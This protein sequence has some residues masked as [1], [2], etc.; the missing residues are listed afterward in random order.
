MPV[1]IHAQAQPDVAPDSL[2]A[3]ADSI[4]EA[5]SV[6]VEA[7]AILMPDTTPEWYVEPVIPEAK[8]APRFAKA[9][10]CSLDSTLS[11]DVDSVLI[12]VSAFQF[13]DKDNVISKT[14]YSCNPDGSRVG[15]FKEEYGFDATNRQV[16]TAVYE[17]VST[18]NTWK[19]TEKTEFAYDGELM[20]QRIDYAW[21]NE[22]WVADK[23]NTWKYDDQE[24]VIEYYEFSRDKN[25]NQ[26]VYSKGFAKEWDAEDRL[27]LD[28]EY[29]AYS[30]GIWTAGTKKETKYDDNG[31]TIEYFNYAGLTSGNWGAAGSTHELWTFNDDNAKTNYEKYTWS[32]GNWVGSSKE[33]WGYTDGKQ[34]MYAKYKWQSNA[35][36]GV[37]KEVKVYTANNLTLSETYTWGNGD[38]VGVTQEKWTYA[39]GKKTL[40]EKNTW[41]NGAWVGVEKEEWEYASGKDKRHEKFTW[42]NGAWQTTEREDWSYNAKNKETLY[43]KHSLE[44]GTLVVVARRTSEYDASNNQTLLMNEARK[45]GALVGTTKETWVYTSGK[46]TQHNKFTW[47]DSDWTDSEE[48]VWAYEG[49]N[50]TNYEKYA[51]ENGVKTG[52]TKRTTEYTSGKKTQLINYAWANNAWVNS[53]KEVWAYTSGKQTLHEKYTWTNN[54]W[55]YTEKEVWAYDGSNQ[56]LHEKYTAENGALVGVEKEEWEYTSGK[57]TYHATSVWYSGDWAISACE[58]YDVVGNQTLIESYNIT[59]TNRTGKEKKEFE[60]NAA[61]SVIKKTTYSWNKSKKLWGTRNVTGYDDAGNTIE[62]CSYTWNNDAWK[63]SGDRQLTTYNSAKKVIEAIT[64]QWST[65]A[66]DWVNYYRKTTTYSGDKIQC[67]A[68]FNWTNN[69]WL[70]SRR[71]DYHYNA[72]GQNDSIKVYKKSGTELVYS[73]RTVNTFD[74]KGNKILSHTASYKDG[75]WVL[76][77]ME[78]LEILFDDANRQILYATWSCDADSIW[79]GIKKDTTKYSATDKVL[80]H[81]VYEGW[82]NNKWV[83]SLMVEYAYDDADNLTLEQRFD[84]VSGAWKG[85]YRN[86]YAY[87]EQGRKTMTASYTTWDKNTNSWIGDSKEEKT[88]NDNG[89]VT[90]KITFIWGG[91]GWRPVFRNV[92]TYD[93]SGREIEHGVQHYENGSW[94]YTDKYVKEYKGNTLVKNNAYMLVN[95]EWVFSSRY[96]NYYDSD[97]QAKLRRQITGSWVNGELRTFADDHYFYSCDDHFYTILFKNYDG[98]LL[99]SSEVQLGKVP[100]YTGA[101]PTK[102]G[103]A[104]YTY[105][106]NGWDKEIVAATAHTTYT[107]TF[108]QTV[109]KYTVTF[110]N[111]D[112]TTLES[113]QWEYGATPTC[114]EPTKTATDQYTYTFIGWEPEVVIVT[115]DATYKATFT[116]EENLYTITW[117]DGDGKTLKTEKVVYGKTPAYTGA[118]PTKSETAQY[119]YAFNN[120]WL[121]AITAVTGDATY[122]AQFNSTLRT[123]TITYVDDLDVEISHETMA[124][125][126]MPAPATPTKAA[127]AQYTYTFDS[128][129]PELAEVTGDATYKA[130]FT[131]TVN[132]YTITWKD[133]DGQTLQTGK[134]AYGETPKYVGETPVKESNAQYTYTFTGWDK[135]IV[136]VTADATYTAQ[137]SQTVNKYTITFKNDDGTTIESKQ[138][139]YGATPTWAAPEKATTAQYDYEFAGWTPEVVTVTGDATYTATFA[140][141]LRSYTVKFL[142]EDGSLFE[143]GVWDY[144]CLP[145]ITSIPTKEATAQYT[146]TFAGWTPTV[147]NVMG[148]ATYTA[149]FT[150]TVNTYTITWLNDDETLIDKT[151]VE[152]GIVPTHADA[153]KAATAEYTY[154]FTG[155]TPELVS[156]TGDATYKATFSASKNSYTITW[157]NDD[158]TLIDN[159]TVEYGVVPEHADA[160]KENTAEFTYTFTGWDN[161][162]VAVT[163]DA[164][165]KATFSAT[166]NSYT[167]TWLNEDN[168]LIDKTTVEYGVVPTHADASKTATAEFTYTFTGWDNTPVAVTGDATYKATFSATKNSYTI[169]WLNDDETLID[170]T[171]VEYGIVPAHADASKAATAEYTYTFTGWTPELVSVTGDATYKATFNATKNSYTITWLNDDESLIDQTT[172]EYGVVPTHVD[173]TKENT[174][175]FTY[176]FTGWTPEV[177]SVTGDATYKATFSATRNKYTIT[178]LNDDDSQIDQTIVEYGIV[179]EHADATKEAT[180][181]FTY[182]FTGWDNTPV[183]VTG[184]AT[185]KATFSATKNKYTITWLN[186]DESLIDNTTVEYGV[187]PTHAD[188]TKENTS[189]FTYTFAGWTPEVVSVT[190]D[191]TYKA[192]FSATKNSY[193]ITWLNDDDSLI[194]QTVVE[195]GVVPEHAD[196]TK[197]NTA[198]FTYTF[199]G[200]DNTPVAVTGDATYKATFSATK[201]EYTITWVD[202]DGNTLKTE[203]VA[204]GETP[205]YVGETPTKTETAQYS[206]EFNNTWSPAIVAVTG[207]ATYTAQF[208]SIV[209]E[210]TITWIDGDGNTLKTEQVAYGE[211]PEYVGETPTKEETAQYSYEFDNTWSPA[212]EAVTG[213]ATYSAQFTSIVRKYTI[214]WIDGDGK[215]LKTEQVAYGETPEY[216]GETPTKTETAQYS[217]EFNNTWSPE[218]E[219]VTG[220]ATYTAQFESI[221]REY[222]ITIT[223]KDWSDQRTLPYG[224]DLAQLVEQII[225][226]K[227]DKVVAVDSIYTLIGWS[228]ELAIVTEDATYEALYTAEART[229]TIT[230][231]DEDGTL[232][233]EQ[234]VEYGIMPEYA[235]E[236]PTKEDDEIYTYTFSGWN[237]AIAVVTGDA[238][239]VATY[240]AEEKPNTAIGDVTTNEP[241]VKVIENDLLYIIRGGMKYAVQGARVR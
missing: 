63:G 146:Y 94:A 56:T 114:A 229:Y 174:A 190:G 30:N 232:L 78:K 11:F 202:G 233:D 137:F 197:E 100:V 87:D 205:E 9:A 215:T 147:T 200:W 47:G 18:S 7:E 208:A 79:K 58:G 52:K 223:A 157:L 108:T 128:W 15:T 64:Q 93:N 37:S 179:P 95:G 175:E 33:E 5:D 195:Y 27:V 168:S 20:I 133:A 218:I 49:S 86:E 152:Y 120:T 105:T 71:T 142:N 10:K 166:K 107:A 119:A 129:V 23:K 31:N 178:W 101:T 70:P 110:Q 176:T 42:D 43:E 141:H 17:W 60:Y 150:Q 214:T 88:F 85:N 216:V 169:T 16:M 177:V 124:Y 62:T 170:K 112:G 125:G 201:N 46:K 184:D 210:Y 41:S 173:A 212:I 26:L 180:A 196:A 22:A 45:N 144:G 48:E 183:A 121:P 61:G 139:E 136:A 106:F 130:S 117:V 24:R 3:V 54:A 224:T 163:G 122:T 132:E 98:T 44:N 72:A 68:T 230:W 143:E 1:Y 162:P 160:T 19:G 186:D 171:T 116:T 39:S 126:T 131:S 228:P 219:A 109:N 209:R 59:A 4:L 241:A 235:G 89:D 204:Y 74:S 66:N 118:T 2:V 138:W 226:E 13:D 91:T 227:G 213:E 102:Q 236:T 222:T 148:D 165:Y 55:A 239:Y 12:E 83:G 81:A 76:K 80:F 151:T 225:A 220:D 127:T 140:E 203:Q 8:R 77:S 238:T 198:E 38:W 29:K 231:L 73:E 237:P 82:E 191:A 167:I 40:Y 149:T 103:D 36:V 155:W 90:S 187:V 207:E 53:D 158:E 97:A 96:E 6:A 69:D 51:W 192:T 25:T 28:I 65:T 221:V 193:V 156:V 35:W 123:Y 104:Q 14:V 135:T 240:T 75:K 161:S 154:T 182:T 111:E 185:Y 211:T 181:E 32:N 194:D 67:E 92:Y 84:W 188:A 113:K 217:Y 21:L 206:Y 153:S 159:T 99:Q 145:L 199:T 115:G 34:T 172:V 189:E 57:N 234:D 134:V 50:E 164:T